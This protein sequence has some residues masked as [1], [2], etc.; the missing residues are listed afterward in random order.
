MGAHELV[1]A[2]YN[3]KWMLGYQAVRLCVGFLLGAWVAR[4]LG[5]AQYGTLAAAAASGYIAYC[6][7]ELGMRQLV[8]K[9]IS[10]HRDQE[11][12]IVGTAWKLWLASGLGVTV[13]AGIWNGWTGGAPRFPW[14]V[15][16]AA[17]LPGTLSFLALHHVWEESSHRSYVVVRNGMIAYLTAAL[18]RLVCLIW[19]PTL[20]VLAWTIAAET[21]LL[22]VLGMRRGHQLGRGWW[23]RGWHRPLAMKF[24]RLGAVL[25]AGQAGTLLLL[26][27]DTVMIEHM[28]GA[29]EAGIYGGATRLSEMAYLLA[30]MGITV[31]LPKVA[32]R[33]GQAGTSEAR[34]LIR[35]GCELMVVLSLASSVALCAGGP[36]VIHWL[37][38]P[39]Y[40]ASVPVLLVHCLAALPYFLAEW[41]HAVLV[42][43][44][45]AG[46][47]AS[48]S[49]LGLVVNVI[50][51]LWWI[52]AH[53]A[54]G[55]AWAT[56]VAYTVC[57][58]LATWLVPDLRWLARLQTAA[59]AAPLR[60][61]ARP[62][63]TWEELQSVLARRTASPA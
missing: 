30:T 61:L 59:L 14:G 63:T 60:W 15:W 35:K 33:L 41:R 8:V 49:W 44:E 21:L 51:N 50:L 43:H 34:D 52:P 37:L 55:A 48:L 57:G 16:W 12:V 27:A 5:P 56:L 40:A 31:M 39:G 23:P 9:E 11:R 1:S 54:L 47:S 45:R 20:T 17:M 2:V 3:F 46:V 19:W 62:R 26:R 22:G 13:M 4:V 58:L 38:G 42:A 32:E 29:T 28:R 6:L 24:L 7:I 25:M 10:Q 53:G 18:A 36:L